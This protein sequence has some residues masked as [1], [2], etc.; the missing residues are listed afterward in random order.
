[1]R[2]K[3]SKRQ[4]KIKIK[5][6]KKVIDDIKELSLIEKAKQEKNVSIDEHQRRNAKG[7]GRKYTKEVFKI[8]LT[9]PD[10]FKGAPERITDLLGL[11]DPIAIELLSIKNMTAF[12]EVF[13]VIPPTLSR[14]R[15][16]IE[17]DSDFAKDVKMQLRKVTR[18]VLGAFYRQALAEGD[19]PR[20]KLWLQ[21][22]EDWREQL[23]VEH[24]GKIGD[25]LDDEERN[26]LKA[27]IAKN[28]TN[29]IKHVGVN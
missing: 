29:N 23:G 26:K 8:W 20:V 17:T 28:K 22:V 5:E 1:M 19:A 27:L 25:G 2:G 6:V 15:S 7:E 4:D 16:D 18:N 3:L 14:W 13:G 9:L 11:S 12:A 24:S 10:Q 21:Y